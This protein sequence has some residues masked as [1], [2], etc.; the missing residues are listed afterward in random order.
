MTRRDAERSALELSNYYAEYATLS[1]RREQREWGQSYMRGR[2]SDPNARASSRWSCTNAEKTST[3]REPFDNALAKALG[4]M[5]E[6]WRDIS[7]WWS[8]TSRSRTE[9]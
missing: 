1:A 8:Q 7:I 3:P 9:R 5:I 4:T 6:F 2:L